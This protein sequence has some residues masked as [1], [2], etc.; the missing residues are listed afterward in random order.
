MMTKM[1]DTETRQADRLVVRVKSHSYQPSKAELE[2]PITLPPGTTCEDL[3]RAAVT[4]VR[5]VEK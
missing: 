5:V 4:P 1:M 3:M 2:K